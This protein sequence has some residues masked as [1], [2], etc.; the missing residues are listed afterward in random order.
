MNIATL[1]VQSE[2][3]FWLVTYRLFQAIWIAQNA[4]K[5][6]VVNVEKNPMPQ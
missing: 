5:L 3:L 6:E 4:F 1:E 2:H